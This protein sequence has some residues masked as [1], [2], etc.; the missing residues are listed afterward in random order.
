MQIGLSPAFGFAHFGEHIT[1]ERILQLVSMGNDMGFCGFQLE[2]YSKEQIEIYT[3]ENICRIKDHYHRLNMESSQFIGHSLKSDI[4]SLE[5]NRIK[6]GLEELK[7]LVEICNK[8][9]IIRTFNIPASPPTELIVDYYETYPGAVQP[10][11]DFHS[12][13]SWERV[14]DTFVN[15]IRQC[16]QV[17]QDAGMKLVIEAVPYG[18]ICTTDSFLRLL[19]CLDNNSNLGFIL[20]TGHIFVQKEPI[21]VAVYKLGKRIFGTHICDNDGCVDDHWMPPKGKI[22]W[23]KALRAL[24]EVGY[25]GPLDIEV[26]VVENPNSAYI[27]GKKY[28]ESIISKYYKDKN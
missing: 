20:D 9:K 12:G 6:Q 23:E 19:S 8:L 13:M 2:T 5:K 22:E 10:V 17:I 3:D 7:K 24:F 15:T 11:I 4:A 26:N 18:V 28:L 1:L 27:E 16:L 14:W 25:E 21:H